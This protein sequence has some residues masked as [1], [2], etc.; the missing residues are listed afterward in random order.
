MQLNTLT[1]GCKIYGAFSGLIGAYYSIRAYNIS[2]LLDPTSGKFVEADVLLGNRV[3]YAF[4]SG[5]I[6]SL[7]G[8]N[9][10]GLFRLMNR[11]DIDRR[12]LKK[13]H[14]HNEYHELC[15]YNLSKW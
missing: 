3:G 13:E 5:I 8:W 9:M 15:G 7:P 11:L 4:L 2:H 14:Y 6:Y 1:K 10:I 12:G